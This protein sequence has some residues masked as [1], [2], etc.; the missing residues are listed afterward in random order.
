MAAP[1]TSN[2]YRDLLSAVFPQ[3]AGASAEIVVQ[4]PHGANL[5]AADG[6]LNTTDFHPLLLDALMKDG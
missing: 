3:T 6:P 1:Q 4:D 5:K 2:K